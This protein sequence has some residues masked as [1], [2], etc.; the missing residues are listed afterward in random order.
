M[1]DLIIK[2]TATSGNKLILQ[3]QA[4]GAVLT[5]ADSGATIAN[6]TL[7]SPTL[8]TP[9]LAI[10]VKMGQYQWDQGLAS[11]SRSVTG[12]GFQGN[13]MEGWV[14]YTASTSN[15]LRSFGSAKIVGSTITQQCTQFPNDAA[16][17]VLS[18]YFASTSDSTSGTDSNYQKLALTSFDSDGFSFTN[19][20]VATGSPSGVHAF[21]YVVYYLGTMS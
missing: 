6:A 10:K 9:A 12:V 7:N 3:D 2:P 14:N 13:Y 5:T 1:P 11:G 20:L 15:I 16:T 21:T 17:S 19:T 8:V 18:N 4:G